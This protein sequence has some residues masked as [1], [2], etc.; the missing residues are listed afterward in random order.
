M[1]K[2]GSKKAANKNFVKPG[3]QEK[4]KPRM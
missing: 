4:I 1:V 3:V 2:E